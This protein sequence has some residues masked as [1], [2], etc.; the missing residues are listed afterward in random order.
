MSAERDS[1]LFFNIARIEQAVKD[2]K[3]K[4][5]GDSTVPVV[6]GTKA[7][8]TDPENGTDRL[9]QYTENPHLV[10]TP[11]PMENISSAPEVAPYGNRYRTGQGARLV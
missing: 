5:Y 11:A 4:T 2:G 7:S 8:N 3:F 6:D 10:S 9:C 1:C